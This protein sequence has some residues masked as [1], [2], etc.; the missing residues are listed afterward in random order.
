[1]I[2]LS[3][4]VMA[5]PDRAEHVEELVEWLG[6]SSDQVVWDERNDRWD[7]GSRAWL[8]RDP[9]A[10]HHIVIQDDAIVTRDLI[11]ALTK[12]LEYIPH[13]VL[14]SPFMG[15]RRPAVQKIERIVRH[16]EQV[17]ASWIALGPLN[18]GVAILTPVDHIEEMLA[19][20]GKQKYPNYDKRIGQF[21]RR[22]Y[23]WPTWYTWPNL[24]DHRDVPSLIGHGPGRVAHQFPGVE[25]S[26]LDWDPSGR[27]VNLASAVT[28][29]SVQ[30]RSIQRAPVQRL[31]KPVEQVP[32]QVSEPFPPELVEVLKEPVR[33]GRRARI[34]E[35]RRSIA[36]DLERELF[37]DGSSS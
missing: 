4:A 35:Q 24:V 23:P 36:K 6:I 30:E 15:T 12:A 11:P 21:Y 5:H 10:T 27:V 32:E 34:R 2:K 29:A 28:M 19:W 33:P 14:V 7:T 26:A 37:K 3:V 1:M 13:R 22:A 16:A 31:P 17:D 8:A 25:A 18:W 9:D 20:G